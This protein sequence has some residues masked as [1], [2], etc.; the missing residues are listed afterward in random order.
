MILSCN[1]MN[2]LA[3]VRVHRGACLLRK[4]FR[5]REEGSTEKVRDKAVRK[6]REEGELC[7]IRPN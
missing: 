3:A 7:L 1:F 4:R 6:R 2:N 5:E